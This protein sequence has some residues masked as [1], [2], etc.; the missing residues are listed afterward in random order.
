MEKKEK[1]SEYIVLE[2]RESKTLGV[3]LGLAI[4][5]SIGILIIG[6]LEGVVEFNLV[7]I[8]NLLWFVFVVLS[9]LEGKRRILK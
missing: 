2:V 7:F 1:Y 4:G 3:L 9:F 6:F 8:S 5:F